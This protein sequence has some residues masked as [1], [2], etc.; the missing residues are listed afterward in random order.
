MIGNVSVNQITIKDFASRDFSLE[1][2]ININEVKKFVR[3]NRPKGILPRMDVGLVCSLVKNF[4]DRT[5]VD[6]FSVGAF[7]EPMVA[8]AN[9]NRF[10]PA[11]SAPQLTALNRITDITAAIP[12]PTIIPLA[13]SVA[14]EVFNYHNVWKNPYRI[15]KNGRANI[16]NLISDS[17]GK[18]Q[19]VT[20]KDVEVFI[21]S[22]FK[23][24]G[25][26]IDITNNF[27]YVPGVTSIPTP[28]GLKAVL[29]K[30]LLTALPPNALGINIFSEII[31]V[32]EVK[33]IVPGEDII[34]SRHIDYL[35]LCALMKGKNGDVPPK[36]LSLLHRQTDPLVRA[37]MIEDICGQ[38]HKRDVAHVAMID[39]GVLATMAAAISPYIH[40]NTS[41]SNRNNILS[42]ESLD[43]NLLHGD[44]RLRHFGRQGNAYNPYIR[45]F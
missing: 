11:P 4:G 40:V 35:N 3:A 38:F 28:G 22:L 17:N 30:F 37:S 45:S 23:P 34:D 32:L 1:V 20:E 6:L 42:S 31:G 21:N 9:S 19:N 10:S 27:N 16:G 5:K 24:A 33:D 44:S 36:V 26:A 43:K 29:D 18:L 15:I 14:A 41:L 7:T 8:N 12:S 25:L 2:D 39:A 13:L